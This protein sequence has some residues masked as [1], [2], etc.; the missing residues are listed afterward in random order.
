MTN[1]VFGI[2]IC[3]LGVLLWVWSYRKFF[4]GRRFLVKSDGKIKEW[5]VDKYEFKGDGRQGCAAIHACFLAVWLLIWV[6]K[7]F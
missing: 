1:I 2:P 7:I 5:A 6:F 3:V 4:V